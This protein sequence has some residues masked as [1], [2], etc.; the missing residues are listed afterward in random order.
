MRSDLFCFNK[1]SRALELMDIKE[2][3]E[4]KLFRTLKQF[5]LINF[6]FTR[7]RYLIKKYIIPDMEKNKSKKYSFLDLGAGGGDISIWLAGLC[8]KKNIPVDIYALDYD[9]RV[10]KYLS[11]KIARSKFKN[12]KVLRK[13]INA[14][15]KKFDYIFANHFPETFKKSFGQNREDFFIERSC[16]FKNFLFLLYAFCTHISS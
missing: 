8:R 3:D 2:S 5:K 9:R 11:E 14:L 4:K 6:L 10:I 1:R 13:N 16:P 12:I 7:S 15:D